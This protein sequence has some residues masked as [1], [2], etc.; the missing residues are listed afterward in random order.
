MGALEDIEAARTRAAGQIERQRVAMSDD[1]P[2]SPA[3]EAA[4]MGTT[5]RSARESIEGAAK[6]WKEPVPV[7]DQVDALLTV[8]RKH[9]VTDFRGHGI[10]VRLAPEKAEQKIP[11]VYGPKGVYGKA[12]IDAEARAASREQAPPHTA[13]DTPMTAPHMEPVQIRVEDVLGAG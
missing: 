10:D 3:V 2:I 7:V 8:L 13:D 4:L 5:Q 1:R 12:H 11:M 9:G 6:A